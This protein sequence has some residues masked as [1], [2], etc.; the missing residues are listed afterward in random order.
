MIC[1][2]NGVKECDGCMYCMDEGGT[3]HCELCGEALY[4]E[5]YDV[6]SMLICADCIADCKK[7]Y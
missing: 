2:H 3:L 5:Y 7:T 1:K 6:E 4:G